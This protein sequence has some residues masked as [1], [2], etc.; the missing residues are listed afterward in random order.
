MSI[1]IR[2]METPTSCDK[3]RFCVNGFTD[4]VPMYECAVQSCENVSVLVESDGKPFDF[5]PDWCPLVEIPTPHGRLIDIKSVEYELKQKGARQMPRFNVQHPVTKEW[6]CFSTIVDDYV[7]DWMDEERYQR[8]RQSEYGKQA[9]EI[10]DANLMD[11][12]EAEQI[13][14][15]RERWE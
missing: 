14:A 6:R 4:T 11:Y 2:S 13:I 10:R 8:W 3:C 15:D 12:E 1:L 5:R 9:G 7:T